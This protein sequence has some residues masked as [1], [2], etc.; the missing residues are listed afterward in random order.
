MSLSDEEKE[1][2]MDIAKE[3]IRCAVM[4]EE[5][6]EFEISSDNLKENCGAF[7][8]ITKRGDLRGCIGYTLP[9]DSL[10][11]IISE[12]AKSAALSDP[13][14]PPMREDELNEIELD[15]SVLSPLKEISDI[16]EIEVGKHGLL[17]EK[18]GFKGL[19]LPQ[20]AI[21]QN[22]DRI[23]FIEQT[24]YKAGLNK[25]AWK[26]SDTIIKTFSAEVFGEKSNRE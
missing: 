2:L 3:S 22:W 13:R 23:K 16:S 18:G 15:I 24:C 17:I 14:F 5:T 25:D 6:P 11:K 19:L 4:G 12:V 1:V 20:V 26:E 9:L 10:Y 7:V 8:T 21:E